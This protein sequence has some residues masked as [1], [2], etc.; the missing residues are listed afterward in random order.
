MH[1]LAMGEFSAFMVSMITETALRCMVV[2]DIN[3]EMYVF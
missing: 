1:T 3:D 2:F